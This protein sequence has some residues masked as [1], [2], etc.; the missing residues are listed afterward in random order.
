VPQ[1]YRAIYRRATRLTDELTLARA[2]GI[3]AQ[4]LG[5]A[6]RQRRYGREPGQAAEDEDAVTGW[7]M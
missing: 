7:A 4:L 6:K 3:Y 5:H 1:G 2:D